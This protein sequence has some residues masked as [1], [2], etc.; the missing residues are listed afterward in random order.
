[1]QKKRPL[2]WVR[3]QRVSR[4]HTIMPEM[5]HTSLSRRTVRFRDRSVWVK[6]EK[7]YLIMTRKHRA[8]SM[9]MTRS[10]GQSM[11]CMPT[12]ISRKMMA[13]L[14]G[15]KILSLIRRQRPKTMRSILQEQAMMENRPGISTSESI[16][17]KRSR[18]LQGMLWI[19]KN[20][21]SN[22]TG[23]RRQEM[24]M[25]WETVI[26]YQIRKIRLETMEMIQA[27]AFMSWK[28]EKN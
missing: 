12:R 24:S 3:N 7:S 19:R 4:S 15:R 11:V 14:S 26:R 25:T 22:W 18:P 28:K 10:Q 13:A 17:S 27:V 6:K 8:L 9:K 23:I 21:K 16:M 2:N 5:E 20:T 1:M